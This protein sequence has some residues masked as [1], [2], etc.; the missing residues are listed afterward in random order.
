[1]FEASDAKSPQ[2]D[3]SG[4]RCVASD[5]KP[6]QSDDSGLRCVACQKNNVSN[7]HHKIDIGKYQYT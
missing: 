1:M 7:H 3:D 5:A 6:P 4:L 2:S